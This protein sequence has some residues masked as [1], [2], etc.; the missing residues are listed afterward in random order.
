M[1]GNSHYPSAPIL[2]GMPTIIDIDDETTPPFFVAEGPPEDWFRNVQTSDIL[3]ILKIPMLGNA[4]REPA[5]AELA[6]RG[7]EPPESLR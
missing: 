4:T 2:V 6:R 1:S 7:I 3:S 5:M